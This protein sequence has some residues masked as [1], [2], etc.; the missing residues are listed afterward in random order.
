M[1]VGSE[2]DEGRRHP[3]LPR[4]RPADARIRG[5]DGWSGSACDSGRAG[6]LET[7]SR[8]DVPRAGTHPIR[9]LRR[10]GGAGSAAGWRPFERDVG[11]CPGLRVT[12]ARRRQ[13]GT[14][15]AEPVA[16]DRRS[17]QG[18]LQGSS[19]QDASRDRGGDS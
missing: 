16:G 3:D 5:V 7:G 11:I 19:G 6:S 10:R 17:V 9:T 12:P 2:V 13:V 14:P 1:G 18:R 15:G 8:P 4:A